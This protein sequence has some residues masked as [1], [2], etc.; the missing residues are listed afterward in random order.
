MTEHSRDC[1]QEPNDA[2]VPPL[3]PFGAGRGREPASLRLL[4]ESLVAE[5]TEG[6]SGP[7]DVTLDIPHTLAVGAEGATLRRLFLPLLE[8]S[9]AVS[10]REAGRIGRRGAVLVTAVDMPG[11]IE[12]EFADS[13][14]GFATGGLGPPLPRVCGRTTVWPEACLAAVARSARG[15]G[16]TLTAVNCPDGGAALTVRLPTLG[17]SATRRAA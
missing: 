6:V 10:R 3:L 5:V 8:R 9:I 11:A 17:A 12:I 1:G 16:G 4:V 14:P 2:R 15:V 7:L 13:G